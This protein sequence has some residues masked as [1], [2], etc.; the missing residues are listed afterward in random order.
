MKVSSALTSFLKT[1]AVEATRTNYRVALVDFLGGVT[2]LNAITKKKIEEYRDTLQTPQ[3]IASRL[4]AIRGFL[5]YCWTEGW[6]RGNPSLTVRNAP[7]IKYSNAKNIHLED[8]QKMLLSIGPT[9]QGLRDNLLLRLLYFTGDVDKVMK[10]GWK[11]KLPPKLQKHRRAY[12]VKLEKFLLANSDYVWDDVEDGY[13][14]CALEPRVTPHKPLSKS[15]IRKLVQKY[16]VQAGFPPK[17]V[18]F[19]AIKRLRARQIWD[20]TKSLAKVRQFCGHKSDKITRAY[21]NRLLP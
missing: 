3:T 16:S 12:Q 1:I 9:A 7:V 11:A 6:I 2:S 4:A 21:L 14:F 8:F 13:M 19:Q 17:H 10:L 5:D 20:Q 15:G 18:D